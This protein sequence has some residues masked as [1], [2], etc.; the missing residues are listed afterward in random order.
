[1]RLV[2]LG[3]PGAGKGTQAVELA[4]RFSIP[5]ISTGDILRE[6]VEVG[7]ALGLQARAYM[8][9]GEFVPDDVVVRMVMDRLG[10]PDAE[11]GFILDGFPRTVPQARALDSALAE[12]D[13]PLTAV[14]QF[15]ISDGMALRRI[16]GRLTCPVCKRIYHTEFSPPAV[17]MV[18]DVEGAELERRSDDDELTVLRR[19]ALYRDQTAPLE[20]FYA[21][22]GLLREIDAEAPVDVVAERTERTMTGLDS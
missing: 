19:L 9:R 8:D 6:Y 15:V 5:R 17:D 4:D 18:C 11:K 7:T 10:E 1:M 14:L 2:L 16:S 12:A 21:E 20:Q 13:T 3:L 22:R